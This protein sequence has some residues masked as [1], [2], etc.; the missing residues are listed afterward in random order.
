MDFTPPIHQ[1]S[2]KELFNIISND[3]EWIKEIQV[4]A[5]RELCLR[6]FSKQTI[7]AEKKKRIATLTKFNKR[8]SEQFARNRNE[9]YSI[10]EMVFI[11]LFFPCSLLIDP[12]PLT[13]FVKLDAGNYKKKIWQRVALI[14][15][16]FFIWFQFL[17]LFL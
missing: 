15:L 8:K 5:E 6:N 12:D 11:I 3:E 14:L 13:E 2:D 7:E 9:S 1:R 16:S 4:L 10:K 17:R